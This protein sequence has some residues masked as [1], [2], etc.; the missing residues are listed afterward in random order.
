[1]AVDAGI[2]PVPEAPRFA[3]TT[4]VPVK[5]LGLAKSRL[6]LPAAH[7]QALALAFALDTVAAL[8][9]TAYVVGVLVVTSDETVA[10]RVARLGVRVTDDRGTGL[11]PAVREGIRVATSWHPDSGV[12]VVPGDL[13]CLSSRDVIA[14]VSDAG[15]ERGGPGA[16]V[17]DRAGTGTTILVQGSGLPALTR[18]G[19]DSAA[20]HRALGLRPLDGAP[21][22]ARHDVDTLADLRAA[23]ALGAGTETRAVVAALGLEVPVH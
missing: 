9:E 20:R 7:R 22:G 10:D 13:P 3:V 18:Y 21:A 14:V 4:V 23:V 5:P 11:G 2:D 16:F 12:A 17:P 6:A 8:T 19:P 1:V 15:A